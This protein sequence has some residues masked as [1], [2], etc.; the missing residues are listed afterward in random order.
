MR[1]AVILPIAI[2][3]AVLIIAGVGGY[4]IYNNYYFYSTDDALVTGTIVNI[5]PKTSGTLTDLTVQVGDFVSAKQI[6]GT[7]K[8]D[9][10]PFIVTHLTAPFDGVIV[11]VPGSVGQNV[12]VGVAVAQETDLK[13]VKITAYVDEGQLKNIHVGQTADIHVDAYGNAD[14]T[15]HV[16]QIVSAAAGQFS[17]LPTQDNSSGNFTKVSQRFQ[18]I[19]LPDD[20]PNQQLM[21]GMSVEVRIHLH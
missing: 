11:Q 9:T 15:G 7:V 5:T 1:R 2:V 19:I 13:G 6:I 8:S 18:V 3:A 17:L 20:D 21:P 10:F 4:L 12:S 16:T 14:F